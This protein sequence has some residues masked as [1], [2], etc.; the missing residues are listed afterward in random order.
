[1]KP[2]RASGSSLQQ[3]ATC[4]ILS[5]LLFSSLFFFCVDSLIL[6]WNVAPVRQSAQAADVLLRAIKEAA[7][8]D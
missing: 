5:H 6:S 4:W 2:S 8:G 3:V 1:M 7:T